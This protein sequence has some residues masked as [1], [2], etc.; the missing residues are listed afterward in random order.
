VA[1]ADVLDN[2]KN[3]SLINVKRTFRTA[4]DKAK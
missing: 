2:V 3:L 4:T 1:E